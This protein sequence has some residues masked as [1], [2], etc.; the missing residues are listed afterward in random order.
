MAG[1]RSSRLD[2]RNHVPL[3]APF[4]VFV[5]GTDTGVGKTEAACALLSLLAKRGLKPAAFKPYESGCRD[6][7]APSDACA[8]REAARSEDGLDLICPHRFKLPLA[9]GIAAHRLRREPSFQKTLRA[10]KAFANRPLVVEGA[11]GLHVP[12]DSRR[13]V[14]DLIHA[15]RL[16][17]LLV[18]RAGL[19]TLNHTVLSLEAL[20]RNGVAVKAV[21]FSCSS[22]R[23]DPSERDN[24]RWIEKR[25]GV[26]I[27]GPVAF[28]AQPARRRAAFQRALVSLLQE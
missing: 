12:I 4:R 28:R 17:V 13:E 11:G 3:D 21:L 5:T 18:A 15:L 7:R 22:R 2:P 27:L 8:L 26:R 16:P 24:P 10:F 6:L 25:E 23:G 20:S 19:G 1:K 9:P 14:I